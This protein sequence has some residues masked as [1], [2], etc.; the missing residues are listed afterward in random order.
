MW[1]VCALTVV[2]V[3]VVAVQWIPRIPTEFL[4]VDTVTAGQLGQVQSRIPGSAEVIASQGV[5]GRFG[6][7]RSLYPFLDSFADG[8]TIP[9][10]SSTVA[11]VFVPN[12]GI[13]AATPAQTRAAI[14]QVRNGLG[15]REIVSTPNVT[16]FL[17]HPPHGTTSVRFGT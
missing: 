5:I 13:E 1:V 17:W 9:V 7:R 2:Q 10:D 11:F 8:Q 3:V 12:Q 4:E 16:A 14:E 15:A 6:G